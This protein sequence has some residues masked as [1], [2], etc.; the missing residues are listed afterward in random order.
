[1]TGSSNTSETE[2]KSGA[3]IPAHLMAVCESLPRP[4]GIAFRI[5]QRTRDSDASA[6]DVAQILAGDPFLAARI[7]RMA[8]SPMYAQRG[9]VRSLDRAVTVL[10]FEAT[11]TAAV[12][13]TLLKSFGSSLQE[14]EIDCQLFWRRSLLAAISGRAL[15]G[16]LDDVDG[17]ESFLVCL[18][19]DIGILALSRAVPGLYEGLGAEQLHQEKLIAREK[20][21]FGADHSEVGA[22]LVDSWDFPEDIGKGILASHHAIDES[23]DT[24]TAGLGGCVALSSAIAEVFLDLT[25]SRRFDELAATAARHFGFSNGYLVEVLKQVGERIP[26]A[27]RIYEM[28][29]LL[30]LDPA[31]VAEE[32]SDSFGLATA[33]SAS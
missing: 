6:H 20:D 31:I 4:P 27:E 24:S 30:G 29:I 3:R 8:N 2:N 25:G 22:W 17:E 26:E 1:M 18:L 15:A 14:G 13:F 19:Q 10:G 21:Q 33:A 23:E 7:V 32:A 11:R 5:L 28:G 12:S 9:E 16:L